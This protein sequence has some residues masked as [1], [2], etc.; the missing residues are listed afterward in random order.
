M[1]ERL[2]RYLI[3]AGSGA[4]V[5]GVTLT[6]ILVARRAH[7]SANPYNDNST[8]LSYNPSIHGAFV[9]IV[10]GAALF[11]AAALAATKRVQRRIGDHKGNGNENHLG[12]SD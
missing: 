6:V 11:A 8:C 1:R 3:I 12:D 4:L 2:P 9:L 10:L 7:C 5:I